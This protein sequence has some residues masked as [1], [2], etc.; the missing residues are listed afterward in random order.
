[1]RYTGARLAPVFL[2]LV[3]ISAAQ[4]GCGSKARSADPE[5]ARVALRTALAAWQGGASPES[6]Q[7]RSP[8][9]TVSDS[10]WRNGYRLLRYE[11]ASDD[12]VVGYELECRAALVLQ[13]PDGRQL[14]EKAVFTVSTHPAQVVVRA[15]N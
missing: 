12:R 9:I 14:E 10:Q 15:E 7:Q 5:S 11:I 8:S 2:G 1:M 4:L 3:L 13:G 6:L